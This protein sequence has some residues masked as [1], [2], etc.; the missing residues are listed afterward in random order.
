VKRLCAVL[1]IS[2]LFFAGFRTNASAQ[3]IENCRIAAARNSIVSLGFPV[4]QERLAF[5]AN[6]KILVLPIQLKD[7]PKYT[8]TDQD[9]AYFDQAAANIMEFSQGI[10][11]VSF[12]FNPTV[13]LSYTASEFDDFKI[14][15]QKT[16]QNNF[17]NS[18][19][20]LV[21]SIIKSADQSINYQGFDAVVIFGSSSNRRQ[22]IAEAMMFTKDKLPFGYG[23]KTAGNSSNWWNP[24]IV[25][26][27]WF[28][29]IATNEG[30]ISNV[31][32]IYNSL[33]ASLLSHELMH[34]YGLTDLYGSDSSPANTLMS[35]N[36]VALLALEKWTLGW[37]ADENVQCISEKV[38]IKA[39]SA[40]NTFSVDY[41]NKDQL[42]VIPTGPSTTLGI[43]V[44]KR[45]SR[46]LLSFYSLDN[47]V[48]PSITA[49]KSNNKALSIEVS[50]NLGIGSFIQSPKY[51]LLI[52]DNIGLKLSLSLI[53]RDMANSDAAKQLFTDAEN[54]RISNAK[55]IQAEKDAQAAAE[56]RARQEAEAKAAAELKAKQEAEATVA[57]AVSELKAKQEADAKAAALKKTTI[58]CVKGKLTKKVTAVKPKCPTGYKKKP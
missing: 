47:D 10:N 15:V 56:L 26:D 8:L 41:S 25:N 36:S 38:D 58:V 1:V 7:E 27:N 6:P 32:L 21:E 33:N 28:D 11:K 57:K 49:F 44:I 45:G 5:K 39:D 46:S 19:Y 24:T 2:T 9:R 51:T 14:N 12:V 37:L 29:P 3:S 34:L 42:L 31:T 35:D 30:P 48:R 40:N 23:V 55:L 52:K 16:F 53:P 13:E 17:K 20:G 22:E 50:N 18:T 4:R 54:T 43:E